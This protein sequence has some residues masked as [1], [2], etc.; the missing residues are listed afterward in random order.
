MQLVRQLSVHRLRESHRCLPFVHQLER[1]L[2]V[3]IHKHAYRG[4]RVRHLANF[5]FA[6]AD[7]ACR[8]QRKFQLRF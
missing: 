7:L 8:L 4:R 3:Y 6:K 5:P 1:H 2:H